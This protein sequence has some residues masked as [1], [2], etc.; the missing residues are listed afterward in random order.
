MTLNLT[1]A[2]MRAVEELCGRK[3]L[4]KTALVRQAIRLYQ[5]LEI[6]IARGETLFVQDPKSKEKVSV[7]VL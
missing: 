1:D 7:L 5:S 4:S 3:G 6:H 2:E